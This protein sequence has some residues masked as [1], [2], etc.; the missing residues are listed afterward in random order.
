MIA[1]YTMLSAAYAD[2]RHESVIVMTEES[3]A[4]AVSAR[5]RPELWAALMASGLPI[6]PYTPPVP[7][8][9]PAGG[10]AEGPDVIA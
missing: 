2:E 3:G 6:A 7:A 1:G 5:D 10:Q 8:E 4:V 9:A